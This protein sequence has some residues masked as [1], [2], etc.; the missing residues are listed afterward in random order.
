[1]NDDR[2]DK[3]HSW[4]ARLHLD[5]GCRVGCGSDPPLRRRGAGVDA[6]RGVSLEV[7]RGEVVAV[8][9]PSGSGKSTLLHILAGLDRPSSGEALIDGIALS[10]LVRSS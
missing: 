9:G 7:A 6:L 8:M 1:M 4:D 10:G 2:S 3:E 5:G